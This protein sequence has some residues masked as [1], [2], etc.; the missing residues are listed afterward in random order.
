MPELPEAETI[1]RTLRPKLEGRRIMAV[2][3]AAARVSRDDPAALAGRAI[4]SV[5]RYGKQILIGLDR[6]WILVKLGM[7]GKLLAGGEAGAYTRAVFTLDSGSLAFDDVRQFGSIAILDAPPDRL[8]PDPLE[9]DA[10]A[11]ADRLKAR[12]TE[13]KRALLDQSFTRGVG[14][15]YCDEALFRAGIHPRARTRRVSRARAENLHRELTALLR[16][17]IDHRGSSVSDYV[18]ASGARGGFQEM[19]RVYQKK[20][21]P[22]PR[23]GSPIRRIVVAQRGTHYC[24]R[25]QRS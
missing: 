3:F 22:C 6:G 14:N 18:D 23:C 19:H 1:V 5:E 16:L 24:A 13:V 2:E 7:T 20:G 4:V 12:D 17:A 10:R 25:C 8:G 9:I 11:F 15:I 21:Q